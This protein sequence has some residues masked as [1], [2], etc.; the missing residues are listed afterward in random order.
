MAPKRVLPTTAS[1]GRLPGIISPSILSADFANLASECKRMIDLGADWLHIDV[2]DGHFVPNLTIG[3]PIVACLRKHSDAF[4]DVHLMV[5]N[6]KQW[7]AE[8]AKAGADM[9]TFHIES[10]IGE[11]AE[12]SS[13]SSTAAATSSPPSLHPEVVETCQLIRAANM[14]VGL[15]LKP[16][17]PID[18]LLPYLAV[19]GLVDM[20]LVMTVRPGFGGQKFMPDAARKC[21][22][23]R[24]LYPNLLIEVDGGLDP[25][26]VK[27][28]AANGANVIVAGSAIFCVADPGAAI[29]ILRHAVDGD[30][31]IHMY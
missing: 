18:V 4:F 27:E 22:V 28:A 13:S 7:V 16:E 26:T 9:Y 10:F 6:P 3:A 23:V 14:H 8:Y 20:V 30:G 11:V 31:L 1:G 17:T 21:R 19:P 5:S 12:G 15:T 29:S 2:M 25:V 24:D